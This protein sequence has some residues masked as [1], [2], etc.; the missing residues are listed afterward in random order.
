MG[1]LNAPIRLARDL[2]IGFKLAMTV[3]GALALL[4][5]VSFFAL[6][7]LVFVT[8]MQ[9][10]VAAQSAVEHQ[11]QRSLLAAQELRVVS[12]ELQVQQTVGGIRTAL[13]RA[14]KQT[15]RA[16]ALMHQ[17][18][19]GPDQA[20]A[21]DALNRLNALMGAVTKA[22]DLRS[23]MLTIRQKR[24]F[25]A[26]PVFETALTTLV[27]ELARGSAM[28]GGVGSVR[29]TQAAPVQA[30]QRD[31]T[32]EAVNR[33]RLAMSRV[34]AAAM[35]F[36]AAGSGS[37][38]NDVKDAAADA[39]AAM[40]AVLAGPAPDAIKADARLTD[41][42]GQA[43]AAASID[44]ITVSRQLDE[45]VNTEIEAASQDMQSS[46][47]K[48]DQT[49]AGRQRAAADTAR[50]AGHRAAT[51]IL[52]MVGAITLL[53]ISLG[54]VVTRM[55]AG[56]IRRLTRIVQGIAD[57]KTHQTVP[58]T[59][60]RDEIGRMA[61]SVETLRAVMRQTFIQSQIIEQLP[62]GVMTAEPDGDVRITYLNT[63]LRR[64]L[65]TVQDALR[66]PVA[67]LGGQTID[68]LPMGQ[69]RPRDLATDP[70]GLP[71]RLRFALGA[72]TIDLRISAT[73]DRDGAYAGP[74][75]TWRTVTGQVHL[76]RQFEQSVG[77]IART[78]A[79]SA[80][81][82]RQA[83]ATMRESAVIAGQ[84]TLAV[85]TASDQASQS[86][87]TAAAGAEQVAISVSEIGRQVAESAQIAGTAVAE[88]QATD[89]CVSRLSEA[90]DR[91][92]A[93][94]RLI[95]DI[96]ART[97]LLALNATIESA[98]AGEAGKGFAVV[99]GEVK[100]LAT[101]TAKATQDIGG[102][103][104]AMQQAT[105]Q[106]VTALRSI[107]A[108]IQRMN[109][110]ATIIAASVEEQG[111][112][113]QSIAQAVQQAAAGTAEVNS[114]IGAVTQ[115]V[116]ETDNRAGVVLDA[117]ME[118]TGQATRLEDEVAKFL[119]AVQQAS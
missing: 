106:A 107:S 10:N 22:A 23:E 54:T 82:V 8:A 79:G 87:S 112:A 75:L 24:V 41:S 98:R 85:S 113:T 33:Y 89:A 103:I 1:W 91:I 40:Q 105:A 44:L 17:V 92:S 95:G 4:S 3:V 18:D 31:P 68:V 15:E 36:M 86:V 53:M 96:A 59:E 11:V 71:R 104:T 118:M 32:I 67:D 64:M 52:V 26:R 80:D 110:I 58:Y 12:R 100:S 19:A 29:D 5:G 42:I 37:A 62:V 109:E 61:A 56:P 16:T 7:R 14:G 38:A 13:A 66:V 72:E 55:L 117:A 111:A 45:V 6:N 99:A 27:T 35:M 63:E 69:H 39:A 90:A 102:Q 2:P 46:F 76:V 73:F 116:A 51:N 97:N 60:W 94:V 20:L 88:A 28:D 78:V 101:Q 9:D 48:L 57:G 43:I 70:A 65:D 50:A 114:N 115:V 25:Q 34:Q 30:D 84:R 119:V 93:V 108:T 49:A 77:G 74:L 21:D 47:D 81:G 83:A